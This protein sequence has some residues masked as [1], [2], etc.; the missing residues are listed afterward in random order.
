MCKVVKFGNYID[1]KLCFY[2]N[3]SQN[4]FSASSERVMVAAASE[5]YSCEFGSNRG[6]AVKMRKT[7]TNQM[8]CPGT[9][10]SVLLVACSVVASPIL[11]YYFVTL[12]STYQH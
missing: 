7:K 1:E 10:R 4:R 12:V 11:R 8:F 3:V 6:D 2:A 9:M 5:E